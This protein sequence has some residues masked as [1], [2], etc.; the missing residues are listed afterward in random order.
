MKRAL[1]HGLLAILTA[2]TLYVEGGCAEVMQREI[3]V[4]FATPSNTEWLQE[5]YLYNQ[6]WGRRLIK[7]VNTG[8]F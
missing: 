6:S 5:S 7:F 2:G 8:S 4:L 1:L 3:E